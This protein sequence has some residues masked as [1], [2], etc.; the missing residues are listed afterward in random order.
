MGERKEGREGGTCLEMA[1]SRSSL[2]GVILNLCAEE[3]GSGHSS[4]A[5][6]KRIWL[7]S[8]FSY[9]MGSLPYQQQLILHSRWSDGQRASPEPSACPGR[10][11]HSEGRRPSPFG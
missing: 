3:S 1:A 2:E 8:V 7:F 11:C 6:L 5:G 10:T 4:T 9:H